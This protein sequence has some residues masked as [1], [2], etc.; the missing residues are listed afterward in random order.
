MNTAWMVDSFCSLKNMVTPGNYNNVLV[1][2]L[3]S[4]RFLDIML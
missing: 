3:Y 1:A 4:M 2:D